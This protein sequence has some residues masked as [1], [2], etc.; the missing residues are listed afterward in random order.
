MTSRNGNSDPASSQENGSPVGDGIPI[1][2]ELKVALELLGL[3]P[4]QQASLLQGQ[5]TAFLFPSADEGLIGIAL[6]ISSQQRLRIG[7]YTINNPGEGLT[8]FLSFEARSHVAARELGAREVELLGIEINNAQ[9]REVLERGG[10]TPVTIAVPEE[11]GGGI[12]NAVSK[13]FLVK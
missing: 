12:A 9:L 4:E 13:I 11:L 3:T 7:I 8:D 1:S 5:P 10:F 2:E 6:Y